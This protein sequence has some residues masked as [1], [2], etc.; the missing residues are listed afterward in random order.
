MADRR[1]FRI[2]SPDGLLSYDT[3]VLPPEQPRTIRAGCVLVID[4]RTGRAFTV[5][6]T[7]L[8]PAEAAGSIAP[9]ERPKH[10]CLKCGKV[11]GVIDD[12]VTCP[13]NDGGSC[14]LLEPSR[15]TSSQMSMSPSG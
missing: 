2:L 6:D 14:G 13:T 5:H 11:E 9:V 1:Q 3:Y 12:Q 7:R 4:E 8:F 10:V 15:G